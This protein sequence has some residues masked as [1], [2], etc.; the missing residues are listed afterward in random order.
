[1]RS[2]EARV[3]SHHRRWML[4]AS[5]RARTA[6]RLLF[7]STLT[8]H[9]LHRSTHFAPS[10]PL[11]F[12]STAMSSSS[13]RTPWDPAKTPYP[14]VRR[15]DTVETFKSAKKGEVRLPD[16]YDWLHDPDSA[17]TQDFVKRQG[18]FT[19]AYLDQYKDRKVFTD[20]LR[21]NWNY[22]RCAHPPSRFP[23]DVG[24][25]SYADRFLCAVSCP[26]LKGDGYYYFT[27]NSGLQPV[28]RCG[29]SPGRVA[30]LTFAFVFPRQQPSIYRFPKGQETVT[31][32]VDEVGGELFFDVSCQ[33]RFTLAHPS[34]NW[35]IAA[36]P[37]LH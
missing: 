4:V 34:L 33:C 17:E 23:Q 10:S 16:P 30:E 28:R 22:P 11:H 15:S 35:Q 32:K 6:A 37:S 20:E 3:G 8:A 9:T 19:R 25:R 27:Y 29:R 14:P 5:C 26:A 31:P 13:L 36:Q 1:M 12:A 2:E 18:D 24:T 21:K 7:G